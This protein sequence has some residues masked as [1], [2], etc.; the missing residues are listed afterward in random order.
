[1][2]QLAKTQHDVLRLESGS[3]VREKETQMLY[4]GARFTCPNSRTYLGARSSKREKEPGRPGSRVHDL[5]NL[6]A[7]ES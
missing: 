4:A 6:F 7:A 1:V 5:G 2:Q 3:L